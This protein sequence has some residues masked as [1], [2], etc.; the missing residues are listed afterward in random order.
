MLKL[1]G[2]D[3][4]KLNRDTFICQYGLCCCTVWP[5]FLFDC[6]VKIW[7]TCKNFL[8]KWFTAPAENCP[9]AYAFRDEINTSVK[10]WESIIF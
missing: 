5:S 8:D 3:P 6:F 9:Y 1:G 4:E 10:R 7:A 2:I